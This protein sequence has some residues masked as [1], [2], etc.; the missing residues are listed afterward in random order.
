MACATAP[1]ERKKPEFCQFLV[2]KK[3][4]GRGGKRREKSRELWA[5]EGDHVVLCLSGALLETGSFSVTSAA[6]PSYGKDNVGLRKVDKS[7]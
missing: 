1:L 4:K 3:K 7:T 2:K 6:L 5:C